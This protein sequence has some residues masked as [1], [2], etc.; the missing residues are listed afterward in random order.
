MNLIDVKGREE[1]KFRGE[2]R[3]VMVRRKVAVLDWRTK[4]KRGEIELESFGIS[5]E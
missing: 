2:V 3:V 4:E 5:L 1:E